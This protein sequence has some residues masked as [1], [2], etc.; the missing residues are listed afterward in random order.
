MGK[1]GKNAVVI[2][3]KAKWLELFNKD[4][5]I[6]SNDFKVY[7]NQGSGLLQQA[8]DSFEEFIEG[9]RSRIKASEIKIRNGTE[10]N[11]ITD[12][13]NAE[14]A[15]LKEASVIE[16]CNEFDANF[17]GL[18]NLLKKDGD[19]TKEELG[20]INALNVK[21]HIG[22][23]RL[24]V[25]FSERLMYTQALLDLNPSKQAEKT[26]L[27]ATQKNILEKIQY[28]AKVLGTFGWYQSEIVLYDMYSQNNITEATKS[29]LTRV[30][31]LS[32]DYKELKEIPL[33][34]SNDGKCHGKGIE[35]NNL[36]CK[37]K[38]LAE[39]KRAERAKLTSER[40]KVKADSNAASSTSSSENAA[41][42]SL[43]PPAASTQEASRVWKV[44]G[45]GAVSI[46]GIGVAVYM[47][48]NIPALKPIT[49]P[50]IDFGN[51]CK[52]YVCNLFKQTFFRQ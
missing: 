51:V 25:Q 12:A 31:K 21:M 10:T 50:L 11:A 17:L 8:Y 45:I 19:F 32:T 14:K 1:K 41:A 18:V 27:T 46:L 47:T 2:D 5:G 40:A 28:I 16:S 30:I 35:F 42:A 3:Y 13:V 24:L 4:V 26:Q 38:K 49:K 44:I 20:Q 23:F 39:E 52:N 22:G 9:Y 29:L 36:A 15:L 37:F 6:L 43:N 48:S 7:C 34:H 33:H